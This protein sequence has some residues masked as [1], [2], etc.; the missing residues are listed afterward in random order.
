VTASST[1]PSISVIV[2]TTGRH[3][4]LAQLVPLVLADPSV[5]HLVVVVDGEDDRSMAVL[6]E[7]GARFDRLVFTQIPRS[8]QL[9]ALELG[10]H[11]TD[12][13]V[14][15]LLDDDVIPAPDLA[16]SHARGHRGTHG[17]V[18]V[19]AM[20]VELPARHADVASV[21]Y[22]R[23]YLTHC[24]RIEAGEHQVLDRLWLGN[25]SLRRSDCLA[26]GLYSGDFTA[27]YHADS[28]LG[29]RLA[30]AGL[31]GRYDPSLGALHRHRRS[32]RAFLRDARRRGAG[33]AE[34]HQVHPRLGPFDPSTFT[35]DLAP[36]LAAIVDHIGASSLA[37]S[38]ARVLLRLASWLGWVGWRS[39]RVS[40]AQVARRIMFVHGATMGE[41]PG[42]GLEPLV[43]AAPVTSQAHNTAV[44]PPG[45]LGPVPQAHEQ[46]AVG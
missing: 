23:D 12:A 30:E 10:V 46:L 41:E 36:T 16:A 7:L 1:I 40:S 42:M 38:A 25:I 35:E 26:V 2:A 9:L 39:A 14:V 15:L 31:V 18:L 33:M 37:T 5:R 6:S 11:L 27:T 13:E 24:A 28:D 4:N 44:K 45:L 8:G 3:E 43:P 32:D 29:F 17:L 22:A 19:G 21:L 34:L 20:P